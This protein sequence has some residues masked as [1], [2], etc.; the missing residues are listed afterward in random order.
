MKFFPPIIIIIFVSCN[1]TNQHN[2]DVMSSSDS[3]LSHEDS[4]NVIANFK[5][6]NDTHMK[7]LLIDTTGLYLAPVKILSAKMVSE[8][9]STYRNVFLSWKNVSGKKITGIKFNW[10]GE[11]A[12]GDPA[13]MGSSLVAGFGGGF[14]DDAMR[15]GST[16]NGTWSILSTD[17]KKIVIAWP[18]EVAFE[19]GTKWKIK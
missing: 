18:I 5:A 10:Y 9:Y 16:D 14:S 3:S 4:L 11:N 19:D 15:P 8:D 2:K 13:D 17:G 7:E 12:F 1:T 6:E